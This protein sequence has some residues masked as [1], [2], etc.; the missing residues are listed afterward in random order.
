MTSIFVIESFFVF[1]SVGILMKII[2]FI[3]VTLATCVVISGGALS[4]RIPIS[5]VSHL[6]AHIDNSRATST[7]STSN[8]VPLLVSEVTHIF[9]TMVMLG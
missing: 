6:S 3:F 4:V 8:T 7:A 2:A 9:L 1:F 5:H